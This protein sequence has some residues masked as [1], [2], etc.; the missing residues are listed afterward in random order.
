MM[1]LIK[2]MPGS[3]TEQQI[4]AIVFSTIKGIVYLH[5]MNIVHRDV[6]AANILLT[7]D[8]TVKIGE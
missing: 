3:L 4:A 5:T 1:D 8:G 2:H 6:K 7:E